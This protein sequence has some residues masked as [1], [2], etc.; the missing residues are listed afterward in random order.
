MCVLFVFVT[1][2]AELSF[3]YIVERSMLQF[4]FMTAAE[5]CVWVWVGEG[6]GSGRWWEVT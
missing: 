3:E 4:V 2:I 5:R 1:R 6:A